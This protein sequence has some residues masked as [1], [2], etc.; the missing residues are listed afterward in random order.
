MTSDEENDD[1][2]NDDGNAK[3][4]LL[5]TCLIPESLESRV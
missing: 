4:A 1:T 5:T 2:D 3:M